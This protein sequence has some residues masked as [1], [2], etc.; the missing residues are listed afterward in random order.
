VASFLLFVFL[1]VQAILPCGT[2]SDGYANGSNEEQVYSYLFPLIL[3]FLE[4]A[5]FQNLLYEVSDLI[6]LHSV[7][8]NQIQNGISRCFLCLI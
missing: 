4:F 8:S 1:D 5:D 2:I 6:S 7:L 3:Y